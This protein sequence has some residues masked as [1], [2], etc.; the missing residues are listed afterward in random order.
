M[1]VQLTPASAQGVE[2]HTQ[3][4]VDAGSHIWFG[5]HGVSVAARHP[6]A[7]I[8]HVTRVPVPSQNVPVWLH[9]VGGLQTHAARTPEVAQV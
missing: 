2:L 7:S 3:P 8:E 1:L 9:V 6:F 5:P 4:W